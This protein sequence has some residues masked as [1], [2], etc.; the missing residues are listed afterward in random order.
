MNVEK[1]NQIKPMGIGQSIII[2]AVASLALWLGTRYLF[3][4]INKWLGVE[5]VVSWFLVAGLGIFFPIL[6]LAGI[7]LKKERVLKRPGLWKNRLR[8][9]SMNR[10]DWL[11]S[12]AGIGSIAV[13]SGLILKGTEAIFGTV[14][15][16]P[17]F[18]AFDSLT[19]GRYWILLVWFPYWLLN[20]MGEEI[21][22]RGVIL[23]RQEVRFGKWTW[24]FHGFCW[25]LFHIPFGWKLL[26]TMLPIL[27]IQ[28][29]V[30]QKR[31]NTWI[32]V[33]IHAGINGPS[34]VAISFGLL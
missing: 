11:W 19:S 17:P 28:S 15:S 27:F 13:F 21:L 23:P 20:I 10:G 4:V 2:F 16:Q 29:Y 32:G 22:W 1:E 31:Q 12:L 33:F 9:R 7:L 3:P 30:V 8:F 34:F 25:A 18:M 6:V 5:T 14:S 26:I 24:I